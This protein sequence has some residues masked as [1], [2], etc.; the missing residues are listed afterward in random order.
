[1]R[2]MSKNFKENTFRGLKD[3]AKVVC[4]VF[5]NPDSV[6]Y[7]VIKNVKGWVVDFL[8]G[9]RIDLDGAVLDVNVLNRKIGV[10]GILTFFSE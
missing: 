10:Q 6:C 1:M 5:N 2:V 4:C 3:G 8:N 7:G 9:E